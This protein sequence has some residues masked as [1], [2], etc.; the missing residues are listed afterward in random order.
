M[1][2]ERTI[3]SATLPLSPSA[4]LQ[5]VFESIA[6]GILLPGGPGLLDPC[7]REPTDAAGGLTIQEREDITASAQVNH[8]TMIIHVQ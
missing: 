8:S 6:S 5:R 1:I 3:S 4:A 7:E 2:V